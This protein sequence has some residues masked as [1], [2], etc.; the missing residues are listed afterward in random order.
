MSGCP[1]SPKRVMIHA[2][3][4]S[5]KATAADCMHGTN[6]PFASRMCGQ[7]GGAGEGQRLT[8][9]L[10]QIPFHQFFHPSHH[11]PRSG[12]RRPKQSLTG[13]WMAWLDFFYF[14]TGRDRVPRRG[15]FVVRVS[16]S[17]GS[18]DLEK[19]KKKWQDADTGGW[20]SSKTEN[21]K[22]RLRLAR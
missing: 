11:G 6:S 5:A 20:M 13:D 18:G 14:P 15:V 19:K 10:Q 8:I 17:R 16:F 3:F 2:A 1:R 21:L 12:Q 4:V 22:S 7:H 9:H